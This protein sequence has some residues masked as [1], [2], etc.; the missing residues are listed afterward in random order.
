MQGDLLDGRAPRGQGNG[1]HAG[2]KMRGFG[3]EAER[4]LVQPATRQAKELLPG[5]GPSHAAQPAA[6]RRPVPTAQRRQPDLIPGL[7]DDAPM[8]EEYSRA[9][10]PVVAVPAFGVKG[11]A[12]VDEGPT[13]V[14]IE[15]LL[16]GTTEEDVKVGER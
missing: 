10:A 9:P 6:A 3:A 15:G 4:R 5:P 14:V 7:D 8:A 11:M 16:N 13:K 12:R 1:R 2:D